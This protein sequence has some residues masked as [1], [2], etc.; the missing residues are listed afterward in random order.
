MALSELSEI[1]NGRG[2]F[3]QELAWIQQAQQGDAAA[4]E[5]V[6]RHYQQPVFRLAYLITGNAEDAEEIAQDTFVRAYHAL[7]KFDETRPL[8]PW[9]MQICRNLARNKRRSAGRYWAAVQRL[10]QAEPVPD[11]AVIA[12]DQEQS[13]LLWQ[14]LQQ[15]RPSARE[16]IYCRYFLD[17]SEAETAVALDLKTGTVKSRLHRAL[18]QLQ[19]IIEKDYPELKE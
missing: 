11:T 6:V 15:C 14:A 5:K 8:P 19:A 4:W 13:Q 2:Q 12:D 17:L 1:E 3:E 9:L 18:K 16:I 10:W 7:P